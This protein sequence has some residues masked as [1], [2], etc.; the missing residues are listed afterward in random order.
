[1]YRFSDNG[2]NRPAHDDVSK[3]RTLADDLERLAA[4]IS[5]SAADLADAP[6][7][8][9]YEFI[10]RSVPAIYGLNDGHP[11][12]SSPTLTTTQLWVL[13]ERDG[14]ARTYSRYYRLGQSLK[15]ASRSSDSQ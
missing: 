10:A 2:L 6:Q 8:D 9:A 5:P 11:R 4:G 12:L 1:M 13:N 14:W 15:D 7:I 3:L